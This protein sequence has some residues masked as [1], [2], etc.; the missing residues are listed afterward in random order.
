MKG[1][2]H[3]RPRSIPEIFRIPVTIID[4]TAE[5]VLAI[6][7]YTPPR[8]AGRFKRYFQTKPRRI[9]AGTKRRF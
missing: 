4:L 6:L 7:K 9:D 2:H 8:L 3:G 1:K 5:M